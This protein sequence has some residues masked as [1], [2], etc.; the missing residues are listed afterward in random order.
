ME[1][2]G[3]GLLVLL[4]VLFA[5]LWFG[6][7]VFQVAIVGRTLM[8]AGPQA[9]GFVLALARRG[10]IGKFFAINGGLAILFGAALYGQEKVQDAPFAGRN[11]WLTLG[12]IVAILAYLHG[13]FA[14]LPLEKKW[15]AL[16]NSVSGAPT[17]EQGKQIQEYGMR[18]GKNAT[19]ST[20]MV[21]VALLLMLMSRVLV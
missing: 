6:G 12:A 19:I 20:A 18:L 21:G 14:N 7:A 3:A 4:H 10:G 2:V 1:F 16:C 17:P 11:L 13:A 9:M 15:I 8:A 5:T